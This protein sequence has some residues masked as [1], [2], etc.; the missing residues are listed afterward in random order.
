MIE[1][2]LLVDRKALHN[3]T[4]PLVHEQ[5]L[6]GSE[7]SLSVHEI[8]IVLVVENVRAPYVIHL[9]VARVRGG[10]RAFEVVG[11]GLVHGRVLVRVEPVRE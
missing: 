8:N 5:I 6:V 9:R 7:Q 11:E 2:Q 4:C 10:T 1:K 3:A